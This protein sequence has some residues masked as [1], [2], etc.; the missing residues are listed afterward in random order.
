MHQSEP[1]KYRPIALTSCICKTMEPMVNNRLVWYLAKDNLI[2]PEQCGFRKR[3]STTHQLV[4]LESF[5]ASSSKTLPVHFCRLRRV[6]S[7][8][9][10]TNYNTEI[11][12][13]EQANFLV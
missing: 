9:V 1:S 13:V 8:P 10:L 4:R 11:P 5:V 7:H 12:V 6:H 3:W 2:T